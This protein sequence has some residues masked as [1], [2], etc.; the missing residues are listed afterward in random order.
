MKVLELQE[1]SNMFKG[2]RR[3]SREQLMKTLDEESV[4]VIG[5]R[6]ELVLIAKES[7]T[8][9]WHRLFLCWSEW[10]PEKFFEA[11]AKNA[12]KWSYEYSLKFKGFKISGERV[13]RRTLLRDLFNVVVQGG[14]V[15]LPRK[16][17]LVTCLSPYCNIC[18]ASCKYNAI[19][20]K[21]G[22]ITVDPDA[23]TS[24]GECI[25]KCPVRAL[26][27]P[28]FDERA[29]RESLL[30]SDEGIRKIIFTTPDNVN[31]S[32]FEKGTVVLLWNERRDDEFVKYLK[33]KFNLVVCWNSKCE[34]P[35]NWNPIECDQLSYVEDSFIQDILRY[36]AFEKSYKVE[37]DPDLCDLCGMCAS[38]CP[39]NALYQEYLNPYQ[40]ILK[41]REFLCLG[42]EAC[43]NVC[44]IQRTLEKMRIKKIRVITVKES[45]ERACNEV[46]LVVEGRTK[47][48]YSCFLCGRPLEDVYD[49]TYI[50]LANA[51][52]TLAESKLGNEDDLNKIIEKLFNVLST[53]MKYITCKECQNTIDTMAEKAPVNIK[54]QALK[55]LALY[56]SCLNKRYNLI[57][58]DI[59]ESDAIK[60]I[61]G[62]NALKDPCAEWENL[63]H[64][65]DFKA[66]ASRLRGK[67]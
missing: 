59:L 39:T 64:L 19:R 16:Y 52:K 35:E 22:Y 37:V 61:V 62:L 5:R 6:E 31:P 23:C 40:K 60:K 63:V 25:R 34:D 58:Y 7:E 45:Y 11:M 57:P 13:D 9:A 41:F 15:A 65:Y 8:G 2:V 67:S 66:I 28:G 24:C 32:F 1:S 30:K 49:M 29:L 55:M 10:C 53:S 48:K 56:L 44:H 4:I 54:R 21:E 14:R 27:M 17:D 18:K 12:D 33:R 38:V 51:F 47:T 26:Y 20:L 43:V 42:C 36:G 3:I 46:K 50:A